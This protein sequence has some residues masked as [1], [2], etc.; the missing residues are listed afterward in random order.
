MSFAGPA[1]LKITK[2]LLHVQL[3]IASEGLSPAWQIGRPL[4]LISSAKCVYFYYNKD[5]RD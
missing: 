1:G 2:L 5:F 4:A 3:H